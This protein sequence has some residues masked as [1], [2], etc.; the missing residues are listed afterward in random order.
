MIIKELF[1]ERARL[2]CSPLGVVGSHTM[3][4]VPSIEKLNASSVRQGNNCAGTQVC[5][6]TCYW[7]IQSVSWLMLYMANPEQVI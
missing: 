6:E 2:T 3:L 5:L 1:E 7:A 4:H